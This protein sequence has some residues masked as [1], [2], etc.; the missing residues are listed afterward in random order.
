[1][2]CGSGWNIWVWLAGGGCGWN[3]CGLV[4]VVIRRYV[5]MYI[6]VDRLTHITYPYSS[7][8]FFFAAASLLK[9]MFNVFRSFTYNIAFIKYQVTVDVKKK[10]PRSIRTTGARLKKP[11]GERKFNGN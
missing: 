6:Y 4:G 11:G 9:K 5:Y 1:M 10:F 3:L 2:A 7:C 8:I